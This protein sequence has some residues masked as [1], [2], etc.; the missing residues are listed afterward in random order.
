MKFI[1][2]PDKELAN[3]MRNNAK[4]PLTSEEI[5]IIKREIARI[6][7]DESKF[8]LNDIDHIHLSTCYN[9]VE[10]IVYVTKNVLP[11]E[12]YGSIHPR[13]LMS[14]AAVLAHE[15][16][17]H[18]TYRNEYISDSKHEGTY[19]S[20][21]LWQD[22]CRASITAAKITPNLTNEERRDLILDAVY[23]AREF[24]QLIELDDFMKETLYGYS[25]SEKCI[26]GNIGEIRFVSEESTFG[27][28]ENRENNDNLSEMQHISSGYDE[29]E[30]W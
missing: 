23:R 25:K 11:D 5:D 30:W 14:V 12:K 28:N 29:L 8:I 9:F 21:P 15:Y 16:Y 20:T 27:D 18:R 1:S 19:Y 24:G 3:G 26:T 13:D 17:G 2:P 4:I 10:D 6:E 7:A 22:E